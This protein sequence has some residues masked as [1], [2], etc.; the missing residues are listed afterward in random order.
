M[1]QKYEEMHKR[2]AEIM[3]IIKTTLYN[4]SKATTVG[5]KYPPPPSKH[6]SG[7]KRIIALSAAW[8]LLKMAAAYWVHLAYIIQAVTICVHFYRSSTTL[9][10]VLRHRC[11]VAR[12]SECHWAGMRYLIAF[13]CRRFYRQRLTM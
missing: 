7:T 8:A 9:C 12:G 4:A 1:L 10:C 2:Q 3:H 6:P 13:I 11:L 5:S